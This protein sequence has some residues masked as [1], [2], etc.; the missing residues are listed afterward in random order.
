MSESSSL[1]EVEAGLSFWNDAAE[2]GGLKPPEGEG[3]A[4]E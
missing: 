4:K 1:T 2:G 3:K